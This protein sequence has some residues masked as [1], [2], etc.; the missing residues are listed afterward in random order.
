MYKNVIRN[1][2]LLTK[3]FVK[4]SNNTNFVNCKNFKSQYTN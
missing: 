1:I 3:H 4:K 2:F